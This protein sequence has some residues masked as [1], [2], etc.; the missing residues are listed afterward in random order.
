MS[1]K[2]VELTKR[3]VRE[4]IRFSFGTDLAASPGKRRRTKQ[5]NREGMMD[6][7]KGVVIWKNGQRIIKLPYIA[8][9]ELEHKEIKQIQ[10]EFANRTVPSRVYYVVSDREANLIQKYWQEQIGQCW[11]VDP[12]KTTKSVLDQILE[13]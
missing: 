2:I 3:Q 1:D 7:P 12:S 10:I 8:P 13:G 4:I 6:K 11:V 5:I 9:K